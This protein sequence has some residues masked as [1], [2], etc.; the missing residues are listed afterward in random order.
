MS[1]SPFKPTLVPRRF[2]D[3]FTVRKRSELPRARVEMHMDLWEASQLHKKLVAFYRSAQKARD[4]ARVAYDGAHN[5]A[6]DAHVA[7][8]SFEEHLAD[9]Y[10][11][12]GLTDFSELVLV[13]PD[14]D[15]E[16]A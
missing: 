1:D 3:P 14:Q 4:M 16:H 12:H 15:P 11:K 10:E 2:I 5:A 7:L 9:L 8:A 13:K 6:T